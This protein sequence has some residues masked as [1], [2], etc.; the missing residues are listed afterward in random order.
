MQSTLAPRS[1]AKIVVGVVVVA[2][3]AVAVVVVAVVVAVAVAVDTVVEASRLRRGQAS[4]VRLFLACHG[5]RC[6]SLSCSGPKSGGEQELATV[7][8]SSQR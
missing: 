3:V 2:V 7:S 6:Q 4:T 1:I 5:N 8:A